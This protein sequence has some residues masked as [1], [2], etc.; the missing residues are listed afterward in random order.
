M[1]RHR[2]LVWAS[3]SHFMIDFICAWMIINRIPGSEAWFVKML[4]Y[5]F[6][7]FAGQLPAGII[8]DRLASEWEKRQVQRTSAGCLLCLDRLCL[9]SGF[10]YIGD[11]RGYR[12]CTVSCGKRSRDPQ[13]V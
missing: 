7:A 4:I 12:E 1:K 3:A 13:A 9:G 11:N 10:P 5:N 6:L 2:R 8:L